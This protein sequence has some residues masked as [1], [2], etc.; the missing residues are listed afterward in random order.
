VATRN[1]RFPDEHSLL[2]FTR[3]QEWRKASRIGGPNTDA[4]PAGSALGDDAARSV[5]PRGARPA[6][7][8][9]ERK[10][11][12]TPT[13]GFASKREADRADQLRT[14]AAAGLIDGLQF[15]VPFLLLPDQR[16]PDGRLLERRVSYVAD[17][18]YRWVDTGTRV[19]EDSKSPIARANRAYVIKRKLMLFVHHVPILEV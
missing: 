17:A 5:S 1:L 15:Q 16:A 6:S 7:A 19:V 10:Y 12:E 14:L 8:P 11:H 4:P 13:R 2:E 18:V 9:V 3:K